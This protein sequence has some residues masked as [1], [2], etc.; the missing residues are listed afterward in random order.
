LTWE[1]SDVELAQEEIQSQGRTG[2]GG[3]AGSK[4]KDHATT[5]SAPGDA[6]RDHYQ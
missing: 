6:W 5:T 3:S 4:A 1:K 2:D